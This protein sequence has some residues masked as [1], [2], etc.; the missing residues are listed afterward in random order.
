MILIFFFQN[1]ATSSAD[2]QSHIKTADTVLYPGLTIGVVGRA[3]VRLTDWV[4]HLLE[5]IFGLPGRLLGIV[6]LAQLQIHGYHRSLT[7]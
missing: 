3:I 6:P 4:V 1:S 2:L 7:D 5:V